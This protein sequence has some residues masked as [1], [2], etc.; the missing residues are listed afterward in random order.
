MLAAITDYLLDHGMAAPD[1]SLTLIE[2]S[3]ANAYLG[4]DA[5]WFSGDEFIR[6]VLR[7]NTGPTSVSTLRN[8]AMDVFDRLMERHGDFADT[9][10][11]EWE[12][13]V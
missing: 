2:Q 10:L 13:S 1:Q 9:V 3:L 6:L 12:S 7:M 8:R 4:D 11:N 5:R